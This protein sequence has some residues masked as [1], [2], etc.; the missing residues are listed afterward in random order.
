MYMIII[1]KN[2]CEKEDG[3]KPKEKLRKFNT[4]ISIGKIFYSQYLSVF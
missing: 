3:R 2:Y 1:V 4:G